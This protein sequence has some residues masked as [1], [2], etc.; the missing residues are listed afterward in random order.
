[1]PAGWAY[2][3]LPFGLSGRCVNADP[4]SLRISGLVTEPGFRSALLAI[5]PIFE[6]VFSFFAMDTS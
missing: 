5:F 6:L 4:P 1:M 3:F 2:F